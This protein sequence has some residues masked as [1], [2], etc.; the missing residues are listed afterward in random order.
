MRDWGSLDH[1]KTRFRLGPPPDL[2]RLGL[3]DVWFRYSA[4]DITGPVWEAFQRVQATVEPERGLMTDNPADQWFLDTYNVSFDT[5]GR[6]HS[7][8]DQPAAYTHDHYPSRGTLSATYYIHGEIGRANDLPDRVTILLPSGEPYNLTWSVLSRPDDAPTS[9][10]QNG[11]DQYGFSWEAGRLDGPTVVR[12]FDRLWR[13]PSRGLMDRSLFPTPAVY[14]IAYMAADPLT[15]ADARL[16]VQQFDAVGADNEER[17]LLARTL[18]RWQP[19]LSEDTR[20]WLHG[21]I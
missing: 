2:V 4:P 14:D 8:N 13:I 9:I 18:L 12:P 5:E 16:L 15:D 11:Q 20:T 7:V 6:L 17:A 21:L 1:L 10:Y 3:F 19:A